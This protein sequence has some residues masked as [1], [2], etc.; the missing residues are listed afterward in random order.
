MR[1][2]AFGDSGVWSFRGSG[3]RGFENLGFQVFRVSRFGGL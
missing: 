1:V 2:S 3:V